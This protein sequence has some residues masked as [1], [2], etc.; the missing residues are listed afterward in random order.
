MDTPQESLLSI[1]SMT[2]AF[3]KADFIISQ[4]F[5]NLSYRLVSYGPCIGFIFDNSVSISN[6]VHFPLYSGRLLPLACSCWNHDFRN[7][8]ANALTLRSRG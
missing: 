5:R 7:D 2:E 1:A 4:E 6:Y 8:F 3:S